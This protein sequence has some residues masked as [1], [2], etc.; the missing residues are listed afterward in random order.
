[1]SPDPRPYAATCS[2]SVHQRAQPSHRAKGIRPAPVVTT[3]RPAH[4]G[5]GRAAGTVRVLRSR[6]WAIRSAQPSATC[7][8]RCSCAAVRARNGPSWP[9]TRPYSQRR[10]SC[11]SRSARASRRARSAAVQPRAA[12]QPRRPAVLR[13]TDGR[14]SAQEGGPYWYTGGWNLRALAAFAVG[15]VLAVG[16]SHSAPGKGPFPEEGLIPFLKP[17]ADYGW[18]VGLTA[19]LLLYTALMTGARPAPPAAGRDHGGP[20]PA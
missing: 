17:L 7:S 2:G 8:T 6:T 12:A 3:S 18:A 14:R 19:S 20:E 5:Q 13:C 10:G 9:I 4:A 1:M 15:G 16:G 11:C